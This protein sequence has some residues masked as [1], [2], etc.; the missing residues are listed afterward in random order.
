VLAIQGH[1]EWRSLVAAVKMIA[2]TTLTH[3]GKQLAPGAVF[4]TTPVQAAILQW[5]HQAR[6]VPLGSQPVS[7]AVEQAE[8]AP[9]KRYRRRDLTPEE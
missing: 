1:S 8:P 4:E 7:P 2:R 5:R 3:Q 6:L 9:R